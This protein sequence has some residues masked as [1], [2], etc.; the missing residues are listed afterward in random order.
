MGSNIINKRVVIFFWDGWLSVSPSMINTILLLH[1]NGYEVD[2]I[3][4]F[5]D[6]QIAED[7][8]FPPGVNIFVTR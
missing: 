6:Y 2:C 5:L 1:K 8:D 4:R 7:I 3:T